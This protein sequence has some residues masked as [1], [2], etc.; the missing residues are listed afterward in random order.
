MK[1]KTRSYLKTSVVILILVIALLLYLLWLLTRPKGE[2]VKDDPRLNF[3]FAIYAYGPNDYLN[4]P[5]GVAT[6][7]DGNIYVAD[8]D[9]KRIL[10]FD[11]SGNPLRKFGD[12]N[13]FAAPT[14]ISVAPDN[15][16]VYVAD[17]LLN[18]IYIISNDLK[19]T[20]KV[21]YIHAPL[22]VNALKSKVYISTF[23]PVMITDRK[24]KMI[25]KFGTRG[26]E[27]GNFDFPNGIA[28]DNKENIYISDTNNLRMQSITKNGKV[29]WIQGTPPTDIMASG[30]RFGL[31]AGLA[32]DENK[33]LFLVDAFRNSIVILDEKGNQIAELG[34]NGSEEGRFYQPAGI[35]YLGDNKI[36]VADKFNNRI[37]VFRVNL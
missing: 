23:G 31:P 36:A 27:A 37:Q 32:M 26:R 1:D 34:E 17:R 2:I 20:K 21:F 3:L 25:K 13:N 6:D 5:H 10:V 33:R 7:E 18:T 28:I 22:T 19:K 12:M 35:T 30:R 15:K 14:G 4:K 24:G 9:N 16:D 8:T 11:S 29:R